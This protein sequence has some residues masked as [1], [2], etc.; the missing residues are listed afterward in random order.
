MEMSISGSGLRPTLNSYMC[1]N[2]AAIARIAEWAGEKELR[3]RFEKKAETLKS[4]ILKC[5]RIL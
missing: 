4:L 5:I 1:A 3:E 2:A